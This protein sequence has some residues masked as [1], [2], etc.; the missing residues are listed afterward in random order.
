LNSIS[1]SLENN[2]SH[3]NKLIGFNAKLY[4]V[5]DD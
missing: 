1:L 5:L 3:K 2:K 4:L